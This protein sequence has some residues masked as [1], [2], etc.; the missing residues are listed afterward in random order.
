[1]VY[2]PSLNGIL[3]CVVRTGKHVWKAMDKTW[4]D[5]RVVSPFL[6]QTEYKTCTTPQS[7]NGGG[8]A[9]NVFKDSSYVRW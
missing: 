3:M 5:D 1:M 7:T 4:H 9:V 2:T 6:S 8:D